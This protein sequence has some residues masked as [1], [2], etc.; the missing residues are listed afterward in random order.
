M[1]LKDLYLVGYN[2]S[3]CIGWTIVWGL[4]VQSLYG[5]IIVDSVTPVIAATRVYNDVAMWLQISQSAA[6][7]EII[8]AVI[9]LVRSPVSVTF[10][11]VMSSIVLLF[12]F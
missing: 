1:N 6:I 7:L 11:Q 2:A 5:S 12:N 4:G 9:G 3:C 10:M 8:H